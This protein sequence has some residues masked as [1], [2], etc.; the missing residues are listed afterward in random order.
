MASLDFPTNPVN[1][2]TY[3]L[4]GVTYYYN[5]A[6]GAWLTQL[7]GMNITASSNTQV[8]FN[9]AN[10]ANGSFGLVFDKSANTLITNAVKV[11][12]SVIPSGATSNLAFNTANAAYAA[13]NTAY[14]FTWDTTV[15]ASAFTAS[16]N[17]GY[18]V[19]T[20]SG[21][22]TVTLPASP[23]IGDKITLLDYA[24][25]SG[26]NNIVIYA[27]GRKMNGLT[28]NAAISTSR[29]A[30]NLIYVD[31][32][33]GWVN[34]SSY[35]QSSLNQTYTVNYLV[36]AGGGGGGVI[37]GGGGA[38]G[39]R[40]GTT[41]VSG[42][43]AYTVTVGAG[44]APPPNG[45]GQAAASPGSASVFSSITSTG[46]GGGGSYAGTQAGSSG[47]SGGG[48]CINGGAGGAGTAGQGSNGGTGYPSAGATA[49]AGGGGGASGVGGNGGPPGPGGSGGNGTASSIT[50]SSVTYAGGGGGGTNTGGVSSPGGSGGG[51]SGTGNTYGS[52]GG[53][54]LGGGAGG[55]GN[56]GTYFAGGTGGSG[57]VIV[58]YASATQLATGGTV[59]SYT[60]GGTTYQVHTFTSSGTFTA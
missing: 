26:T 43:T 21:A 34:Y 50:G 29:A 42:G 38:G 1:N 7:S 60:S 58:S 8:L 30:L 35:S 55:G 37:G 19:N 11:D 49:G 54:N 48:G 52:N 47:G 32:T 31:S 20:T 18:I 17:T 27:N 39:F 46:G 12:G 13:A 22:V 3:S 59:T 53:A 23:T 15:K 2:Q 9:D 6:I 33:Q 14:A 28:V 57:I 25:T 5:S 41:S 40:S 16:S 56:S 45:P 4:N 10:V 24:G 44:G 36:V 51:G